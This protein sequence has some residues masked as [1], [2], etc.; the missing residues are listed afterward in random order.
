MTISIGKNRNSNDSPTIGA[1]VAL[2]SSTSTALVTTTD[3]HSMLIF[4][5]DGNQD[6]F[7]KMQAASVDND[8]KGFIIHKG[9][10]ATL[11]LENVSYAG[12]ISAITKAGATTIYTTV[13]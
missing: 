13:M 4:T 10:T 7:I 8:Q 11:V 6:A 9:T 12:E 5:N 3:E 2:N 1:G